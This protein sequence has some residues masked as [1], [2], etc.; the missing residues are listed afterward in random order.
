MSSLAQRIAALS[1][2]QRESLRR[3]LEEKTGGASKI[4]PRGFSGACPLSHSQQLMW[5]LN[6]LVAE[7]SVYHVPIFLRLRGDLNIAALEHALSTIVER[8]EVLRT[9]VSVTDGTPVQTVRD[10]RPVEIPVCEVPGTTAEDRE[11]AIEPMCIAEARR[12]FDLSTDSPIRASLLRAGPGDHILLALANHLAFDGWSRK[13]FLREL[14]VLYAAYCEQKPN[15]LPPLAVQYADFAAWQHSSPQKQVIGRQIDYWKRR[16]AGAPQ[17]LDLPSDRPRPAVQ[18]F[19]GSRAVDFHPAPLLEGLGPVSRAEGATQFMAL[20][21]AFNA[22]LSRHSGRDDIVIGTPILGRL[23]SAVEPLIGY[24]SNTLLIRTDLSGDPPFRELLRRVRMSLVEALEHQEVPL[25]LLT[26]EM[27]PER[28]AGRSPLF[29]VMFSLTQE[30]AQPPALPGLDVSVVRVDRGISRLDLTMGIS[31]GRDDFATMVE[32]AGDLF[33]RAT[34]RRMVGHF[35]TLL[36]SIA[37]NPDERISRLAILP[38]E[39]RRAL[40]AMAGS[41]EKSPGETSIHG[42]FEQQ[43]ARTPH[44]AAV[45]C[46]GNKLTYGELNARAN[47]VARH[48]QNLGLATGDMA[49]LY[50]TRSVHT[51]VG[52][53][54][55]LKAGGACVPLDPGYP[56]ERLELMIRDTGMKLA[57]TQSELRDAIQDCGVEAVALDAPEAF[58]SL[59]VEDPGHRTNRDAIAYVIYTSGSTGQPKGVLLTHRGLVSHQAFAIRYYGLGPGDRVL[60]SSPVTFDI[61]LEE[62]LPALASGATVVIRTDDVV[63][64]GRGFLDWI[65]E[66]RITVLDLPTG[67]WHQWTSEMAALGW[68]LPR[69]VRLVIVGGEKAQTPVFLK[70]R[71]I[72]PKSVRWINTYGPTEA[73]VIATVYEPGDTQVPPEQPLPIGRPITGARTYILDGN[74]EPVPVGIP[75]E[76]YLGGEIPARGYLNQPELTAERFLPDPFAGDGTHCYK[77][78]DL[79]RWLADGNIEFLG[80][81][82]RQIKIRGYRVE[83][84][85]IES[86]L[87]QY[88]RIT[89]AAVVERREDNGGLRLVAYLA[90]A[91]GVAEQEVRT[92]LK[93]RLPEYMIPA[94]FVMVGE[95]PRTDRGKLDRERLPVPE[96]TARQAESSAPRDSVQAQLARIWEKVLGIRTVGVREGFFDLG[97]HSLQAVSMFAEIERVFGKSLPPATLFRAQTIEQL[98]DVLRAEGCGSAWSALVP[99][100]TEGTRP[101][102]FCVHAQS[103]QVVFYEALARHLGPEQPFYGLQSLGLDGLHPP[104]TTVEEMAAHYIREIRTVQP[105]G[106]YFLGG[107][108]VG[109]YIAFEMARQ[110]EAAGQRVA[111]LGIF[112]TDGAWR[113]ATTVLSGLAYHRERMRELRANEKIAYLAGRVR[114]RLGRTKYSAAKSGAEIIMRRRSSV[115]RA[116][117]ELYVFEMNFQANHNY[118]PRPFGGRITYFKGA[119]KRGID[120]ARFWGSIASGLDLREV[121]GKGRKLFREPNVQKLAA[122][123]AEAIEGAR[124]V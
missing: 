98:S 17:V 1:P 56:K 73:S 54:A 109:A 87:M 57:L 44:A 7:P 14:S 40:V 101:P 8:H 20:L 46:R 92:Y 106:P 81:A 77:T 90:T 2:E 47:Q 65:A 121:P 38:Q 42:M 122:A 86:R 100:Q 16:L 22:L 58:A 36:A 108:C 33:E 63:P 30:R 112:D 59:P 51:V 4:Q 105:A 52:L 5:L 88:P 37:A 120:P 67:L 48:L 99:I 6:Q 3:K 43:A 32:Y 21:A 89:D 118:V 10:P 45:E 103:G 41:P 15:P 69:D 34:I 64:G 96:D 114:F 76:L 31:I 78:G 70:W 9:T 50:V 72:A 71:D 23:D 79:A 39:E 111:F 80:R 11:A 97:G 123:L 117:H 12:P 28:N 68:T 113:T 29:Q 116:W 94:A 13:I 55:I 74:R 60:Q 93:T 84:G 104:L 115:P 53:M 107:F 18:T 24:F 19:R 95:L 49:G 62:I 102:L 91:R 27:H 119:E 85:E 66:R 61:S 110:F 26:A 75:G 82:D 25:E 83:P 35:G 124:S